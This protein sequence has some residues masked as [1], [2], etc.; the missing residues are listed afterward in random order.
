M[1]ERIRG[2]PRRAKRDRGGGAN[3]PISER[4]KIARL[5]PQRAFGTFAVKSTRKRK[6]NPEI[7]LG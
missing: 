6:L 1:S 3:H 7:N 4:T 2:I 5:S